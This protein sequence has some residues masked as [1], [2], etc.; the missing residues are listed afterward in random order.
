MRESIISSNKSCKT[1]CDVEN[2]LL[3][4]D[5]RLLLF[6]H[7]TFF[8][9]LQNR[10]LDPYPSL[11]MF[12]I[13]MK[14]IFIA[15]KANKNE[16]LPFQRI[17]IIVTF[18]MSCSSLVRSSTHSLSPFPFLLLSCSFP[19]LCFLSSVTAMHFGLRLR[20]KTI[21]FSIDSFSF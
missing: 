5:V 10:P 13:K 16:T 18:L 6:V 11:S 14:N 19:S 20:A 7:P 3:H 4:A 17:F 9:Q 1:M 8:C 12:Y 21:S 2:I 15:D